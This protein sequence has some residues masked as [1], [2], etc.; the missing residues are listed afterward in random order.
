MNSTRGMAI[1]SIFTPSTGKLNSRS[2][3]LLAQKRELNSN[4]IK[5]WDFNTPPSSR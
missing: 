2:Q 5:I 1:V 3:E 4:T